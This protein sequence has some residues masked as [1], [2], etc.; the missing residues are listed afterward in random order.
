MRGHPAWQRVRAHARWC[1]LRRQAQRART[2]RSMAG[3]LGR[4]TRFPA[5][6][7]HRA[8]PVRYRLYRPWPGYRTAYRRILR[9]VTDDRPVSLG[10]WRGHRRAR[11]AGRCRPGP[12]R[13]WP[14]GLP[15]G[16]G[17]I[18]ATGTGAAWCAAMR[19]VA[20]PGRR[21]VATR[22]THGAGYPRAVRRAREAVNTASAPLPIAAPFYPYTPR[23]KVN[24]CPE[25]ITFR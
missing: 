16:R 13:A 4:G 12:S 9:R 1:G 17:A 21:Q 10:G 22:A 24:S 19:L 18:A 7:S 14:G 6:R 15:G 3:R 5:V 2:R 23:A 25:I 8:W 20:L 11:P